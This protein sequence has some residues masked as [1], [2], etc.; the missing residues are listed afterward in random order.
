MTD[1]PVYTMDHTAQ[2]QLGMA[3]PPRKI[4]LVVTVGYTHAGKSSFF[5]HIQ[6]NH[7]DDFLA[8]QMQ[9][10][11]KPTKADLEKLRFSNLAE[12]CLSAATPSNLPHMMVMRR[13]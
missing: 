6:G 10:L 9:S 5:V 1:I 2:G 13:G 11:S 8:L 12:F 3:L 4:L 7:D